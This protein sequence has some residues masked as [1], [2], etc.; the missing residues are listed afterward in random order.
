M[1][2]HEEASGTK[3]VPS[4][5]IEMWEERDPLVNFENYLLAEGILTEEKIKEFKDEFKQEIDEN[6]EIAFAEPV[7]EFSETNELNDVYKEFNY[8]EVKENSEKENIRLIDA[9]SQGLKQSMERH[10]NLV[11]MGQDVAEYGGVFKITEGFV[12]QFGKDRVRN[13]PICESAIVSTGMGLSINGFKAVVEMQFADF[14]SSGFN[15]IVNYLAKSHYRWNEKADVVIRMPCG[16]GVGAGPFHSQ[17]NEAWF[18]HTPGL[19]VVYPAFPYDAKGLL[20]TSIEDPNPV[21]FFEHKALYRSIRQDV[22]TDYFTL[23]L[24]KA[25]LLK[26]GEDITIITYGAGVHWALETLEQ[27][28]EV[29]ADLID[30]RTLMPLDTDTI[31]KSVKKTGKAIILQEDSMFGGIASDISALITENCFEQLDAP[32]KR[33]ASL[34]TPIPFA[35]NLEKGYLSKGKFKKELFNLLSY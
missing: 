31:F 8:Q 28:P 19:K 11:I 30:L 35:A 14:V 17:T 32:V 7:I 12:E 29:K 18:T 16:A 20:A 25:A 6:L 9:I 21:L 24:G 4:E 22:P 10:D 3:Y 1:R 23:P 5:L 34:E 26:E 13:T 27:N 15:P 2:G 33:V